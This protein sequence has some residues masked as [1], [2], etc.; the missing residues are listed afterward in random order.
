MT[1]KD[2]AEKTTHGAVCVIRQGKE[3]ELETGIFFAPATATLIKGLE[4]YLVDPGFFGEEKDISELLKNYGILN[5]IKGVFITHNHPDHIG[6]VSSCYKN[7]R[8]YT[9]DSSFRLHEVNRNVF[10]LMTNPKEFYSSPG[11]T[12]DVVFFPCITIM[13]TPGHSGWD[14]SIICS[15]I[16]DY[17]DY[18]VA[19]VGDLFWSEDDFE[20]DSE[21][22][23]LCVNPEMQKR[24]REYIR[25]VVKP[26]VIVPGHGAAFIPK[27]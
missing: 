25:T 4:T 26:D 10:R 20:H 2:L 23:E 19:I 24:S 13:S 11:N 17:T 12:Y 5:E 15:K 16:G 22:L 21:F 7:A 27:Y 3:Q 8:V 18:K 9:S 6:G 14:L 1:E